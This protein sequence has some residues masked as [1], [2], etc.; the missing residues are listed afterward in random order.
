MTQLERVLTEYRRRVLARDAATLAAMARRWKEVE[1]RL[2]AD[3]ETAAEMIEAERAGENLSRANVLR[4]ERVEVLLRQTQSVIRQYEEWSRGVIEAGQRDYFRLGEDFAREAVR[5]RMAN[6]SVSAVWNRLAVTAVN[7]MIGLTGEGSPLLDVLR[8]RAVTDTSVTGLID[9]L[10][11][12]LAKG[13]NPRETARAMRDGLK[14]GLQKA[15]VI[16]RTEQLRAYRTA[17]LLSYRE[18]SDLVR[19]YEWISACDART[20]AACWAMHGQVF[21]LDEM[22]NDHPCGRCS[23]A[24][25]MIED[26]GITMP[27]GEERLRRLRPEQQK[28]ILGPGRFDLWKGGIPL[29]EFAEVVE[30]NAEWGKTIR[31]RTLDSLMAKFGMPDAALLAEFWSGQRERISLGAIRPG[32]NV[33][34]DQIRWEHIQRNHPGDSAWLMKHT[35]EIQ[36]AIFHPEFVDKTPR[37]GERKSRLTAYVVT[38]Q[39]ANIEGGYPYLVVVVQR[40]QRKAD[41]VYTMFRVLER[42]IFEADGTLKERWV[43]EK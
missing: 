24:P 7:E 9:E 34:L 1:D 30:N 11:T 6:G 16:A 41:R 27:D 23:Y 29:R 5:A 28:A 14:A 20:C 42:F 18:N 4:F 26:D 22:V 12:A 13:L 10:V 38:I 43:E 8:L 35:L 32:R 31:L 15:L 36:R 19:G 17:T 37:L 33:F 3:L 25:V 39:N 40:E 2:Q 21:G